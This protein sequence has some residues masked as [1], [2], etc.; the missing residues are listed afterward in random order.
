MLVSNLFMTVAWGTVVSARVVEKSDRSFQR[1]INGPSSPRPTHSHQSCIFTPSLPMPP[2]SFTST[3][4]SSLH[5]H[6]PN[7]LLSHSF[8]NSNLPPSSSSTTPIISTLSLSEETG[9]A[10]LQG[11]FVGL[12]Y[13]SIGKSVSEPPSSSLPKPQES[14]PKP[15]RAPPP[16]PPTS[17]VDDE[18]DDFDKTWGH[19]NNHEVRSPILSVPQ[20]SP[21]MEMR[22]CFT[23][24]VE[25]VRE[26]GL[27]EGTLEF[28][29]EGGRM[30]FLVWRVD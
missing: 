15:Y 18:Q 9:D 19:V 5:H 30:R 25:G 6:L 23:E 2:V 3:L 26:S 11:I 27:V 4:P 7:V 20:S 1:P 24:A 17:A 8:F 13:T 21:S 29:K 28:L 12:V 22:R 14:Q 10:S 16:P